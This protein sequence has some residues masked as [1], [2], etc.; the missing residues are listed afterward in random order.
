MANAVDE[1]HRK[2]RIANVA[3]GTL[4]IV[5]CVSTFGASLAVSLIGLSIS[6]ARGLTSTAATT[7][8]M[9]KSQVN[10]EEIN[11]LL[12]QCQA[13]VQVIQ[14]YTEDISVRVQKAAEDAIN[15]D[16]M[17]EI[18]QIRAGAGHAV[19]NTMKMVKAEELLANSGCPASS[20]KGSWSHR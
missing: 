17:P 13:E 19:L 2:A 6:T 11:E 18:P 8:N 7:T 16:P 14:Q 3:R 4:G 5:G 10:K 15:S 1:A 12:G 9:V 20:R